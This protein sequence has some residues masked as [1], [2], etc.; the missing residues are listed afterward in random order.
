M[1]ELEIR[2][3][4]E[5]ARAGRLSVVEACNSETFGKRGQG[6]DATA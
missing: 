6:R 3:R 2:K 5:I 1:R 4:W